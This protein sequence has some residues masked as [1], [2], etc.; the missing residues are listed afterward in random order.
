MIP[1]EAP[2][3]LQVQAAMNPSTLREG[4]DESPPNPSQVNLGGRVVFVPTLSFKKM[5][6]SFADCVFS[7]SFMMKNML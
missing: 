4:V 3:A 5:R 1:S 7:V 2:K 6:M